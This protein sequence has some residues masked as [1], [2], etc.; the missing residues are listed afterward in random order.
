MHGRTWWS[1]ESDVGGLDGD[2]EE[3]ALVV[4][5]TAWPG[6]APLTGR[7]LTS[8]QQPRIDFD[9]LIELTHPDDDPPLVTACIDKEIRNVGAMVK[10]EADDADSQLAQVRLG[11]G[12]PLP[13]PTGTRT[14]SR[15]TFVSQSQLSSWT[16]SA[17]DRARNGPVTSTLPLGKCGKRK[18]VGG[19]GGD[20]PD[21]TL[22]ASTAQLAS[23]EFAPGVRNDI[24][25]GVLQRGFVSSARAF[26]AQAGERTWPVSLNFEPATTVKQF[27]VLLIPSGGLHGLEGDATFRARLEAYA[28]RGG[29]LVAFAQ[30]HGYEFNALPGGAVDG[31]GWAENISCFRSSLLLENWHPLL[32]G[33]NRN[34]L[35]AHVDGYF[36]TVP[37]GTQ[38]LLS[39][40]ANGRPGAI[41][42]PF[43]DGY[44]FA[45]SIYDDWGS[46]HGQ[47]SADAQTLLRNL[48][49]WAIT[50][51]TLPQYP[52]GEAIPLTVPIT[53]TAPTTATAV[54]LRFVDPTRQIALTH[55]VTATVAPG[56]QAIIQPTD[57]PTLRPSDYP[58]PLG[59]WRVDAAL[60]T[61]HATRIT[62][63]DQVARF[64][65]AQPPPLADP[66]KPLYLSITAPDDTF[67]KHTRVPFTYHVYNY[68]A[69]PLTVTVHYGFGHDF[70]WRGIYRVL[71]EDVVVPP[72]Q[73]ET[74]GELTLPFTAA[75][76][77]FRL[78]GHVIGGGYRDYDSYGVH[79]RRPFVNLSADLSTA[80]AQRTETVTLTTRASL[81]WRRPQ[82][83]LTTT[84]HVQALDAAGDLYYTDV[85]TVSVPSY[86]EGPTAITAP[87]TIPASAA[88]GTGRVWVEARTADGNV[89]GGDY[90]SLTIPESPL[91]F[92]LATPPP[93]L[94]NRAA[95]LNYAVT[96]ATAS[97]PVAHGTLTHTLTTP[98]GT[99]TPTTATSFSVAPSEAQSV[100]V[101]L[102]VPLLSFGAYTL[103]AQTADEYG[104][105]HQQVVWS[106]VPAVQ[107]T[108]DRAFYRARDVAHLDVALLNPGPFVLPLTATLTIPSLPYSHTHALILSSRDTLTPTW[109]VPIPADVDADDHRAI[110]T[111]RLPGGDTLEPATASLNV[112][113]STLAVSSTVP[114]PAESGATLPITIVNR[115]GVDTLADYNLKVLDMQGHEVVTAA[116]TG[117]LIQAGKSQPGVLSLP[118]QLVRGHYTLLGTVINLADNEE[119]DLFTTFEVQGLETGLSVTT[120]HPTYVSTD[121]L[122]FTAALTNG[123]A[124]LENATYTWRVTQP[125]GR[126]RELAPEI[127][128]YTL[129]VPAITDNA[130]DTTSIPWFTTA[131]DGVWVLSGTTWLS[132]TV[133][134]SGLG[135]DFVTALDFDA[136]GNAWLA[137]DGEGGRG[138]NVLRADGT[139]LTY[140]S[141]LDH[142]I[143]DLVIDGMDNVWFAHPGEGISAYLADGTWI[144]Y[145]MANS[146]LGS[147]EITALDVDSQDNVWFA[148]YPDW[149]GGEPCGGGVSVHLAD[150]TWI[151]YTT[152]NSGLGSDRV[153]ALAAA[154]NGDLW[155]GHDDAYPHEPAASVR[156]VDGSWQT[157]GPGSDAVDTYNVEDVAV[158]QAGN[159][160]F[161]H[162]GGVSILTASGTWR[163]VTAEDG[164]SE[165][166]VH[167][168]A[169]APNGARWLGSGSSEE[170]EVGVA[171]VRGPLTALSPW[172]TYVAPFTNAGDFNFDGVH[173]VAVDPAGNRWFTTG[174]SGEG[175]EAYLYRLSV[176]GRAWATFDIP[177]APGIWSA[178]D[179]L[180]VDGAGTAWMNRPEER[181][182][183]GRRAD[184]T[185]V[186]HARQSTG[187]GLV[188][189]KVNA[190]AVDTQDRL[191][192]A[193]AP[194][195]DN[196]ETG[197]ASVLSGTQWLTYTTA[198][199]GLPSNSV[200][201][202]LVDGAGNA[203]FATEAGVS[204]RRAAGTWETY[205]PAN[206]PLPT[207]DVNALAPGSHGDVWV[208]H[209]AA[210]SVRHADGTWDVYTNTGAAEIAVQRDGTVWLAQDGSEEETFIS[211][212]P[213]DRTIISYTETIT[214]GVTDL[215]RGRDGRPLGD[216]R[217]GRPPIYG[218]DARIV[219][220]R[221][222]AGTGR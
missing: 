56:Q 10:V 41:L 65:V 61:Q 19:P 2:W 79:A 123:S 219:A 54:A 130:V 6:Y 114:S 58:T 150:G 193:T 46:G 194:E 15:T 214:E 57:Y 218:L 185:W 86:S 146:G 25:V 173:A 82:S 140:T 14:Y 43:G 169:V 31:Y 17:W 148:T 39:R 113:P 63:H 95:S 11:T 196:E 180:A 186:E 181:G 64:A 55:T 8:L 101:P 156:R 108:W 51:D 152:A 162:G 93:L 151:T 209:P 132:Y 34:T 13:L 182:L 121:P 53:N 159:I 83:A 112:P 74:P 49:T 217:C 45:T 110:L 88:S 197:G 27:P 168:I 60:L 52:P 42:Y 184:G 81:D 32:S 178:P 18:K 70:D 190:L 73:G 134:N 200:R 145:T 118:Q 91:A 28:R 175:Y 138:V 177:Y 213:A 128:F 170:G 166:G 66:D 195:W 47:A 89:V 179:V 72:A 116:V 23:L 204:V 183:Q 163:Y 154:P 44:V 135:A 102:D 188:S 216:H 206:T 167:S 77:R 161:G 139:W 172:Q 100:T 1:L 75:A 171:A 7:W 117:Q 174:F 215:G 199:S 164:L 125:A 104:L 160:W 141:L 48:L 35:T 222:P 12:V 131:G 92:S 24:R 5:N 153:T 87:L 111:L 3:V 36:T 192:I 115:G 126:Y 4:M 40:T 158:D 207:A 33:F 59:I 84:L 21:D 119:T 176:D 149:N 122:T 76:G 221:R 26:V 143:N 103:T 9:Y 201:D 85:S 20:H 129:Q 98:W 71:A 133:A 144:T 67:V 202:V 142:K 220:G 90:A 37:T 205:T 157:F 120:D 69:E 147:A 137:F 210:F 68:G 208:A 50:P 191:W 99:V 127:I 189:D 96:N 187:G 155:F 22:S 212:S 38:T 211:F 16:F 106:T 136:E 29:T 80:T 203:W 94:E 198:N 165:A 107:Q 105:R 124:A 109:D 62:Q 78:R 97:L 30:Q